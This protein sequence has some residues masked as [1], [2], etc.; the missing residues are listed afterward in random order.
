MKRYG[1]YIRPCW[2]AFILGPLLMLTEVAG[3]VLLPS[4]MADIINVGAANHDVG[5]ILQKGMIMILT[6]FIMMA[7]GVGGAWFASVAA[8]NF[9]TGLRKDAFKKIQTFSFS[10]IDRFSTGSLVT[11]LTNDI[12]Q[13]QN[14][15]MMA[16]R[17]MLRAPG[18]LIGAIIMAFLMDRELAAVFLIVLP[19]MT[20]VI[21]LLLRFYALHIRDLSLCRKSWML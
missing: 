11:R 13:V 21:L 14:L 16:L 15:I 1:K 17:M 12:T 18:M 5:Y 10:E 4:F 2:Y 8:I 9:G 19:V 3:E 20:V 6:A 7:G